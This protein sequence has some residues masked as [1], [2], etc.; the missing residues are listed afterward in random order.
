MTTLSANQVID[1]QAG[2]HPTPPARQ[3]EAQGYTEMRQFLNSLNHRQAILHFSEARRC[4][5]IT[6]R[7]TDEIFYPHSD[8][9]AV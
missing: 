6:E 8:R 3:Q 7:F 4:A 1:F 2:L 9:R 5:M